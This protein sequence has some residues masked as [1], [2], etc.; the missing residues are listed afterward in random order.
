MG[1]Y[2]QALDYHNKALETNEDLNDRVGMAKDYNN[3]GT[4][5][6]SIMGNYQ[7]AL[8]Y[9][10]KALETNEDLNGRVGMAKDY[11]N[12]GTVTL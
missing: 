3:I 6:F 1:N 8:D 9:H 4:V 5:Y 10:N 2:Q 12:I 11:N 7:Q